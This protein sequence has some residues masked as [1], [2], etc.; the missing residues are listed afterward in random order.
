MHLRVLDLAPDFRANHLDLAFGHA[1]LPGEERVG[2][3]FETFHDLE[4]VPGAHFLLYVA[5][6]FVS[7]NVQNRSS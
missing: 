2:E 4:V 1:Q 5:E 3:G 7:T 6:I